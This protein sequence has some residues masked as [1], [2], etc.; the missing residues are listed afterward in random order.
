MKEVLI[1]N[2]KIQDVKETENGYSFLAKF[3]KYEICMLQ[4]KQNF[5]LK[6]D[7]DLE[8]EFDTIED[9]IDFTLI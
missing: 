7:F 4:Q 3:R 8:F 6:N 2:P 5:I 1:N 9:A